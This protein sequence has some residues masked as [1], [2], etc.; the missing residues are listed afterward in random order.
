MPGKA[1][2]I[3]AGKRNKFRRLGKIRKIPIAIDGG[4]IVFTFNSADAHLAIQ[5]TGYFVLTKD[6]LALQS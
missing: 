6:F 4:D 2:N 5:L 1:L 3:I